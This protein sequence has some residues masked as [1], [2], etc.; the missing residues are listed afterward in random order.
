MD[1]V[2]SNNK[3]PAC[4][5][6]LGFAP[7]DGESPS[8]EICPCCGIQFGY[9][10]AHHGEKGTRLVLDAAP[11]SAA[12]TASSWRFCRE[13]ETSGT[14]AGVKRSEVRGQKSEVGGQRAEVGNQ[15]SEVSSR[16]L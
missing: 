12:P 4:G 14:A 13:R 8:D 6:A 10:D 5:Y 2:T 15:K 7:W 16:Q 9:D 11:K 3:C 1:S